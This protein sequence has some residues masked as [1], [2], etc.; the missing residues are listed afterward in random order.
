MPI[1][2]KKLPNKP[3]YQVINRNTKVVHSKGT[4]LKKAEAQKRLLDTIDRVRSI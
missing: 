3:L 1:V 2:I 4:T